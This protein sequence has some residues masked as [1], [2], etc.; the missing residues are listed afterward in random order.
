MAQ[1]CVFA[2]SANFP[3][4][5]GRL[6][7]G[8]LNVEV[9]TLDLFTLSNL[10]CICCRFPGFEISNPCPVE[11]RLWRVRVAEFHRASTKPEMVRRAVR[12]AHGPEQG[13][14]THH[15]EPSRRAN[16]NDLNPNDQNLNS[17]KQYKALLP[18]GGRLRPN[19]TGSGAIIGNLFWTLEHW[20]FEFV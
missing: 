10:Y 17:H 4:K 11:S 3:L 14:R 13:R 6:L 8:S 20:E 1:E 5:A 7:R 15:P 16:S 9:F 12:Q 2:R 19:N 18:D